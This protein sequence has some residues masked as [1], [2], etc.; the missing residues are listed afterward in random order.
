VHRI[1][2]TC[3][4]PVQRGTRRL[5]CSLALAIVAAAAIVR[6]DAAPADLDVRLI[7]SV[8]T[9]AARGTEVDAVTITS[10][11]TPSSIA[12]AGCRVRGI[13]A[14]A[15]PARTHPGRTALTLDFHQVQDA[16]GAWH[17]IPLRTIDVDNARESVTGDGAILGIERIRTLPS[18]KQALLLLAAYA[19]PLLLITT[20]G[21]RL[22]RRFGENPAVTYQPG[23]ELRLRATSDP[24]DVP[25]ICTSSEVRERPPDAP[26]DALVA[27]WPARTRNGQ[28]P[29][30]ADWINLAFVGSQ[31]S[32]E[33]A[34]AA[35]GWSTAAEVSVRTD[36]RV[37]FSLAEDEGYREAPVSLLTLNGAAP[38]LVFQK[39][40]NTF[41][42]RHHIR[43]WRTTSDLDD[44]Q[45]WLADATHDTGIE[46]SESEKHF[47]HRIDSAIDLERAKVLGDL[48]FAEVIDSYTMVSRQGIPTRSR[49][50]AGD[51][52]VTDGRIAVL[53]LRAVR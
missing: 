33:H 38:A 15:G 9:T 22:A 1:Q 49:N 41:A 8:S 40:N 50:A 4:K 7:T 17:E 34:F 16:A 53:S 3:K 10:P 25:L 30:L 51:V 21:I 11:L 26:L 35:A 39:Q 5:A 6:G 46:F 43:V 29:R 14:D 20:E 44:R 12:P 32:I 2:P 36:L 52:V 18:T 45:V 48:A 31:G 23:T 47:T 19:H 42:K 37:F 13:V 28:T 24:P 27:S